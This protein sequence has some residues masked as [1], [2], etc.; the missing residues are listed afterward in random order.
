M[1]ALEL[2][3][4]SWLSWNFAILKDGRPVAEIDVSHWRKKG[5]L[6]VEGS[7]YDVYREGFMS[8][9][10]ILELKWDKDCYG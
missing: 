4:R 8:G 1:S 5:V 9:A 2:L 6:E 10:F 3:P 7:Q